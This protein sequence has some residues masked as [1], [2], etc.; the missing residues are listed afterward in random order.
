MKETRLFLLL[1]TFTPYQLNRFSKF[2]HSS[3]H[4]EDKQLIVLYCKLLP[5]FKRKGGGSEPPAKT[6]LWKAVFI[7]QKFSNLRFARLFSDLLKKAEDFLVTD[8]LKQGEVEKVESL[9][10][11][12]TSKKLFKHY[13]DAAR[14]ARKKLEASPYREGEYYLQLFRLEAHQNNF[15]ELQNQRTNE[16]N[17][18]QTLEA[19][20]AFYLI[21]KLNYLAALLHYKK[22]LSME[23]EVKLAAEILEHLSKTDYRHIPALNIIYRVVQS[24]IEPENEAHFTELKS[25]LASH[26]NLFPAQQARNLYAFA[27][28]YCIRSVNGGNLTYVPELLSLYKQMLP[29]GIM[30]DND[31]TLSQFDYKNIVSVALRLNETSWAEKFIMTY[32]NKLPKAD[33]QNAYTFNLAKLYFAKRNFDKVLPLLQDVVYSDIFYQLDSKTTLMKTYYELGEYLPMMAL[34]ESFRVLLRRKKLISAQNRINYTNFMRFTI[35]LHRVDVKDTKKL[36]EL[37]SNIQNST[38]VADKGWL[39]EK[40]NELV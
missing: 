6:E 12:Y 40:L 32:K 9:L 15:I 20:D 7:R 14:L 30:L 11:E 4:N 3:Y 1:D 27:I 29:A 19:L 26:Y 23:G 31:G 36:T 35:R 33:R 38:N 21:H 17:I 2:L 5:Y 18:L 28:N 16:K 8:K 13:P 37:G 25:L 22:F 10:Q 34:K 24:L 39:L